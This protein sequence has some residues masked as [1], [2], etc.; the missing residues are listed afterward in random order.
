M[1]V[2]WERHLKYGSIHRSRIHRVTD[3]LPE[4]ALC[5]TRVPNDIVDV[6]YRGTIPVEIE[7]CR[8]CIAL[9]ASGVVPVE[10]AS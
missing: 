6:V 5:G 9:E 1:L 10:L 2:A 8:I 7:D 4:H 3:D